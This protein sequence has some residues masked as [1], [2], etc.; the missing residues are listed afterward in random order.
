MEEDYS[1]IK[2]KI[3]KGVIALQLRSFLLGG[4][5]TVSQIILV[6]LLD[7][8]IFGTFALANA[9]IAFSGY[10]SDVGL[11][12]ALIQ[13]KE[14]PTSAELSTV[15]IVQQ[16]LIGAIVISGLYL[17]TY[18]GK[19]YKFD[20]SGI[21]LIKALFISFFISSLKA[22]PSVIL[23]RELEFN[24][25][26]VPQILEK[27]SYSFIV[28]ILAY[29][30]KGI[31]SF[32]WAVI[33]QSLVGCITIYLIAPWRFSLSFSKEAVKKLLTFG[34][35]Y[36]GS[37]SLLALIKDNLLTL[38]L[39]ILLT[40]E[41]I[42]FIFQSKTVGEIHLRQIMDNVNRITFPAYAR[43]QGRKEI[44]TKAMDKTLFFLALLTFPATFMMVL[45]VK[46]LIHIFP[47]YLKWEPALFSFYLF[48]FNSI[49]AAF[50]SPIVNALN[51]IGKVK[52]AFW[53]MLMWTILT[54]VL[55]PPAIHI[56]GFNGFAIALFVI[57][58]TGFIPMMILKKY[59]NFNFFRS[60]YKPF[61]S[62]IIMIIPIG[63]F[64][65]IS[66]QFI[67]VILSL[68]IAS[69]IYI[70]LVYLWMWEDVFPYLPKIPILGKII[71][72]KKV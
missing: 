63:V 68:I 50:S 58:F 48:S 4:I 47:K 54:W 65:F 64:L 5:S 70:I 19:L 30:G 35:P 61:L 41:Q 26:I 18:F 33:V 62:S 42:G 43:L 20:N 57:S 44:L 25:L 8:V 45:Y 40:K 66:Q 3:I 39:G 72:L 34:I 13:K 67:S 49:W 53:L 7:P 22:I 14:K 52:S 17:S 46:P 55:V 24:L 2:K 51:A 28:I 10:F 23:E 21:F 12:A 37:N 15:F 71:P 29:M 60:V 16:I 32:S 9:L 36:Q 27:I 6:A 69:I 56:W 59:I 1:K 31:N 38:F 11:A